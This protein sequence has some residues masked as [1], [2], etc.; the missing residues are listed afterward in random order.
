MPGASHAWNIQ[1][2]N[3]RIDEGET[4]AQRGK[5]TFPK[6]H[7][8][9]SAHSMKWNKTMLHFLVPR[10]VGM[11]RRGSLIWVLGPCPSPNALC[12]PFAHGKL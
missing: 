1:T 2:I 11:E 9:L 10:E 4:E 5:M 3:I 8:K 6:L 7:N 12:L